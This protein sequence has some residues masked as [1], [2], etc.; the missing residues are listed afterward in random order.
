[1]IV[2]NVQWNELVTDLSQFHKN[3]GGFVIEL[4]ETYICQ[5]KK[6]HL[7]VNAILVI[8]VSEHNYY[9]IGVCGR[10]HIQLK[11]D[12]AEWIWKWRFYWLLSLAN[13]REYV[14]KL[15]RI[16]RVAVADK[17]IIN[18]STSI[19]DSYITATTW[20]EKHNCTCQI[21]DTLTNCT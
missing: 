19:H 18:C 13:T 6:A 7:M 10:E 4:I 11:V 8:P 12:M 3:R 15:C 1:M 21:L 17:L 16:T 14:T 9:V 5:P 2:K 20:A